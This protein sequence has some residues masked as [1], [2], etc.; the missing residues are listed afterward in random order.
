M[1]TASAVPAL[2]RRRRDVQGKESGSGEQEKA[3]PMEEITDTACHFAGGVAGG[4]LYLAGDLGAE[5]AFRL[6]NSAL[7]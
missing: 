6:N 3:G 1:G 5:T 2:P 7:T 4:I